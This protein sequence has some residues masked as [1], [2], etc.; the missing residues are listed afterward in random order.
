MTG[1]ESASLWTAT[2]LVAL[3]F[4][5]INHLLDFGKVVGANH[6]HWTSRLNASLVMTACEAYTFVLAKS[7]Q[8][9]LSCASRAKSALFLNSHS[10]ADVPLFAA[11]LLEFVNV[12][13]VQL[14]R[15]LI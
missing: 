4:H 6:D 11:H 3:H 5:A 1:A 2:F 7:Y 12:A 15:D 13:V 8:N 9:S 14:V 10:S